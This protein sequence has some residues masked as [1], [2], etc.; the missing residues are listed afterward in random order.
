MA[1]VSCTVIMYLSLQDIVVH[2]DHVTWIF[3]A[4]Q[5]ENTHSTVVEDKEG[6]M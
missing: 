4:M 2:S 1:P 6:Y 5:G 3:V